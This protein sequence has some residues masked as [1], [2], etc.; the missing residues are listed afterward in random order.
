MIL[1]K[2]LL[3]AA[4]IIKFFIF[5]FFTINCNAETN[6]STYYSDNKK[7]QHEEQGIL[8]IMY[9]RFGEHKYP[10]T[11]IAVDIFKEH[12]K[13]IKNQKFDFFN[14]QNLINEFDKVKKQKKILITVDDGFTSFFENAWPYLKENKIPFILFISTQAVGKQGYMTWE[15]IKEI[16]KEKFAFIGN[17]SHTHDYLIEFTYNNFMKD[18]NKSIEIFNKELGYNPIYFS[19]P[20]GEYSLEHQEFINKKFEFAFGQH[21]GVIDLNKNRYELP[22]FP[23]NEKYGDLKRFKNV[24]NYLPLQYKKATPKDKL[25]TDDNNPPQL[26][27][28]FFHNQ[29]NL[30][31]ITC[32]SNE[33]SKWRKTK[34]NLENNIIKAN[35]VEKFNFRRGRINC[36]LND[37]EGWRFFGIQFSKKSN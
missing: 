3:P 37:K 28:E 4:S 18:I 33:G 35:F 1:K 15:Q 32:Y 6:Y 9:H 30:K 31:N 5:I 24:I 10:S 23:I 29:K 12:M 21:S 14:P 2:I 19:Y 17:H 22:R 26:T 27:V 25:I 34:I 8:S 11:N 16:E 13:L 7:Y 20:F 36:S